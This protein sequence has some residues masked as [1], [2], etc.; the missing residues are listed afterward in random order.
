MLRFSKF[1]RPDRPGAVRAGRHSPA[2]RPRAPPASPRSPA[3]AEVPAPASAPAAGDAA[4][5]SAP[6]AAAPDCR[7]SRAMSTA[8]WLRRTTSALF[9]AIG[10]LDRL[11]DPADRHRRVDHLGQLEEAGLHDRVDPPTEARF[12]RDRGGVD[13]PDLQPL[14]QHGLLHLA[15]QAVEH[16]FRRVGGIEQ[17][18]RPGPRRWRP[19]RSGR[20]AGTGGRRRTGPDPPGRSSGSA[21]RKPADD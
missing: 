5:R 14:R 21:G 3:A 15:R 8:A 2:D 11:L 18:G 10:L 1:R 13:R 19:R 7:W 20:A 12:L 17:Q 9:P 16:L 4:R 6:R